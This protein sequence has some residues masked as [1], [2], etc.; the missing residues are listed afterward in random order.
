MLQ[1]QGQL[2]IFSKKSSAASE[3]GNGFEEFSFQ[4]RSNCTQIIGY[5]CYKCI[6]FLKLY[7]RENEI[8]ARNSNNI[9]I[10]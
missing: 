8:S 2:M 10:I 3:S 7:S 9:Q 1:G 5:K 6:V 4:D